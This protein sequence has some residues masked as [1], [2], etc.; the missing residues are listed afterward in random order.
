MLPL[1]IKKVE[2]AMWKEEFK[3]NFFNFKTII[4][5]VILV[6]LG[7]MSFYY[8]YQ[9]K[10]EF[11]QMQQEK[12]EDVNIEKLEEVIAGQ[13][14]LQFDINFM[15]QSDFFEIYII[16]LLLFCGIFLSSKVREMIENG[17]INHIISRTTYKSYIKNIL[18]SQSAYIMAIVVISMVINLII[19]YIIGGR[20][21]GLAMI[22][23]YNL[24]YPIFLLICIIQVIITSL[25]IILVN[26]ISL[27]SSVF[28]KKKL[29]IQCLPFFVFLLLPLLISSTVGNIFYSIGTISSFFVPFQN[30]KGIYWILQYNFELLYLLAELLPYIIYIILFFILYKKNIKR[31][32]E[33]CI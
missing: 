23:T 4:I 1:F 7:V 26:A 11:L 31:F 18:I 10:Y 5:I 20:G 13:N 27:L 19:G 25:F 28:I 33:D 6:A 14:G 12:P 8:S 15:L 29:L 22:G 32:S 9:E 21:N 2:G 16:V 3:K 17:Q 30:L 24:N